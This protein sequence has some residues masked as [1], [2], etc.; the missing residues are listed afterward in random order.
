MV[1]KHNCL[2]PVGDLDTIRVKCLKCNK[3]AELSVRD[4]SVSGCECPFCQAEII[5]H[6]SGAANPFKDLRSA[7]LG[8]EKLKGLVSIEFTV[9]AE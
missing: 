9:P 4:A 2:I 5:D 8:F 1:Q 3:I 7:F 6:R